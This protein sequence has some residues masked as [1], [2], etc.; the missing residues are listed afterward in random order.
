MADCKSELVRSISNALVSIT[1]PETASTITDIITVKLKDYDVQRNVTALTTQTNN[2]EALIKNYMASAIIEGKAKKTLLQYDRSLRKLTEYTGKSLMTLTSDDVKAWLAS[3]KL[4]GLKNISVKNQRN[5]VAPF[6]QWLRAEHIRADN[7][8]ESIGQIRCP[9]EEKKAFTAE[10][11]D[12]IRSACNVCQRAVVEV[13]LSSGVRINELCD[14]QVN[15]VDFDNLTIE[16]KR[17]KGGRARTTFISA[18]CKKHLQIYLSQKKAA[19]PFLFSKDYDQTGY[20]TDGIRNM[21]RKMSKETGIHIH[22][23][24]FRR[25]LA[26]ECAKRGMPIQEIRIVLGHKSIGTTQRYIDTELTQVQASYRQLVA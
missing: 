15:D 19:S 20:T 5:N 17:G 9:Q 22:P 18:V 21:M 4:R 26:T 7:P 23:H 24:R 13:L 6:F 1:D 12:T 10:D 16:V 3:M 14:L 2:D 8:C 25:T 11:I